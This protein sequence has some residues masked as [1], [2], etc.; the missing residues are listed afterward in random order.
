MLIN[1]RCNTPIVYSWGVT[2]PLCY[3]D[4]ETTGLNPRIHKIITIQ[5]QCL[6]E[7]NL[8]PLGDLIILKEWERNEKEILREFLEIFIGK[9]PF[10]FIPMGINILFDFG[11]LYHRVKYLMPNYIECGRLTIDYLFHEKPFIDLK[12]VLVMMN[13]LRFGGYNELVDKLMN[14]KISGRDI[15]HLYTEGRYDEI[16]RYIEEEARAVIL[17]FRKVYE[18]LKT[19]NL[20]PMVNP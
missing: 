4:I 11:F 19:L 13:N 3:F 8:K 18:H 5:Y 17:V 6:D 2:I 1:F 9:Q 12:P 7:Q 16:L 14:I 15:P 20:T 10:D